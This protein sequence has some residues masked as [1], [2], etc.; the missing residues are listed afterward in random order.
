MPPRLFCPSYHL[1]QTLNLRDT[2][3]S[4]VCCLFRSYL[5]LS[6]CLLLVF[7]MCCFCSCSFFSISYFCP[8]FFLVFPSFLVL[9]SY[10]FIC[11]FFLVFC[12]MLVSSVLFLLQVER[13]KGLQLKFTAFYKLLLESPRLAEKIVLLQV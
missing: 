3:C 5:V 10:P 6:F 12:L 9:D 1:T 8:L 7:Y 4:F 11:S 13:L 2:S